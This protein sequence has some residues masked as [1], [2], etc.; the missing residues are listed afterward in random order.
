MARYSHGGFDACQAC[1]TAGT[2]LN[3]SGPVPP[4][5]QAR[6]APPRAGTW[7]GARRGGRGGGAPHRRSA[8]SVARHGS[9]SPGCA[10]SGT[11]CSSFRRGSETAAGETAITSRRG[12][13]QALA[14]GL[15]QLQADEGVDE[16]AAEAMTSRRARP[17]PATSPAPRRTRRGEALAAR[18]D[19]PLPSAYRLVIIKEARPRHLMMV[20]RTALPSACR[21]VPRRR[22]VLLSAPHALGRAQLT[23]R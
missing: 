3:R 15:G 19:G 1:P 17:C 11:R 14:V 10:S 5:R 9:A 12:R 16:A 8:Q 21:L 22:R 20:I 7:P 2:P 6:V 18:A 4:R 13:G 23:A